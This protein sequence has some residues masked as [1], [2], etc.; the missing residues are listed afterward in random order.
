[1]DKLRV[2]NYVIWPDEIAVEYQT[3]SGRTP[4]ANHSFDG[5]LYN[6]DNTELSYCRIDLA[7]FAVMASNWL[8]AG[9][10]AG[11]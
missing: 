6:L 9:L 2:Y 8:A 7:D 10:Y 11:L 3:L 1:V 5:Y 4:C